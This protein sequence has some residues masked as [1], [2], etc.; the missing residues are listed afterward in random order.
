[1][2]GTDKEQKFQT[3][4]GDTLLALCR[5]VYNIHE[6]ERV[7]QVAMI[8]AAYHPDNQALVK[9]RV[10]VELPAGKIIV[11]PPWS[12]IAPKLQAHEQTMKGAM[13]QA[14]RPPA[15]VAKPALLAPTFRQVGL[16]P[17]TSVSRTLTKTLA[18]HLGLT[19]SQAHDKLR[20]LTKE[21]IDPM[22]TMGPDVLNMR[23]A[24]DALAKNLPE[25]SVRELLALSDKALDENFLL[26]LREASPRNFPPAANATLAISVLSDG[27]V[28]ALLVRVE[29]AAKLELDRRFVRLQSLMAGQIA[30]E[31]LTDDGRRPVSAA[32]SA[33]SFAEA[34]AK[35]E[36]A[37]TGDPPSFVTPKILAEVHARFGVGPQ[38]KLAAHLAAQPAA[39]VT[40]GIMFLDAF[41]AATTDGPFAEQLFALVNPTKDQHKDALATA[42]SRL[43][44]VAAELAPHLGKDTPNGLVAKI[45]TALMKKWREQRTAETND[46]DL[47]EERRMLAGRN[48]VSFRKDVALAIDNRISASQLPP[49]RQVV[50]ALAVLTAIGHRMA[51]MKADDIEATVEKFVAAARA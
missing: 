24:G 25:A 7:Y 18:D 28:A 46:A 14:T 41:G 34:I 22:R 51:G 29:N 40:P 47:A 43:R 48:Y 3:E 13:G 45:A 35:L 42:A 4:R 11:Y 30:A 1:M 21:A 12:V 37:V 2:S 50:V 31:Q 17:K 16:S 20:P 26:L 27:L 15:A 5:R 33:Q 39:A 8:V 36:A 32:L 6:Q 44:L 23:A 19:A 9:N 38:N 49:E 10:S